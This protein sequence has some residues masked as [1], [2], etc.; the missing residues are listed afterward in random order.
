MTARLSG[1]VENQLNQLAR[2][3]DKTKKKKKERKVKC[4][5]LHSS[6]KFDT[7]ISLNLMD[8][9][10]YSYEKKKIKNNEKYQTIV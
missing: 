9:L 7:T 4:T 3:S 8:T 5:P 6:L 1:P 10:S 2:R